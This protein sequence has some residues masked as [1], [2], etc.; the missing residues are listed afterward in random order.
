VTRGALT[1][2]TLMLAACAGT[3]ATA[4]GTAW[5]AN[6]DIVRALAFGDGGIYALRSGGRVCVWTGDA[7]PPRT[8]SLPYVSALAADASVAATIS[9]EGHADRVE[10]WSL[11][12]ATRVHA[13]SFEQG[14]SGI[15]A[16]SAS[17]VALRL[18]AH[19]GSTSPNDAPNQITPP[20]WHSALWTFAPDAV[21]VGGEEDCDPFLF[22]EVGRRFACIDGFEVRWFD[23]ATRRGA[24]SDLARDWI[25]PPPP[26]PDPEQRD[27]SRPGMP[28]RFY[29]LLSLR[30]SPNGDDAYVTYDRNEEFGRGWRLERWSPDRA[31]GSSVVAR[32]AEKDVS[33]D[34]HLLAVSGDG[35]VIVLASGRG[36][37]V[38]RRAPRYEAETLAT[39]TAT[40]AAV[41]RDR[42]R[43][44]TGHADGSLRLWD[45][46]TGRLLVTAGP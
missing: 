20:R 16:V 27:H 22:S 11:P 33:S 23:M 40:S 31:N 26:E 19:G 17:A 34:E 12:S 2:S 6:P 5:T 28:E 7:R 18:T 43:I 15:Q 32:L 30:L 8:F 21:A 35:T 13:R 14:I 9:R 37:L 3:P 1:L 46:R 29:D 42:A 36:P 41:S 45:A 24:S 4:R 44:V 10:V 39:E 38:V 25:P